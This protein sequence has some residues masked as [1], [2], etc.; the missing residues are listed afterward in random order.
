MPP[1]RKPLTERMAQVERDLETSDWCTLF[2][3]ALSA[4]EKRCTLKPKKVVCLGLGS[5]SDWAP[6]RYQLALL[7]RLCRNFDIPTERI[8]AFD[9]VFTKEDTEYLAGLDMQVATED[10][11]ARYELIDPTLVFM[12]HCDLPFYNNLFEINWSR[13]RLANMILLGNNL[14]DYVVSGPTKRVQSKGPLI[15]KIVPHL[16]A[17]S[18]PNKFPLEDAAFNDLQLQ[19]VKMSELPPEEDEFWK[20]DIASGEKDALAS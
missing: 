7:L 14:D 1:K 9:P 12:P 19:F 8:E 4:F 5:L 16:S 10:M 2:H 3:D 11:E 15:M 6:A 17:T 20:L 13:E 18:L